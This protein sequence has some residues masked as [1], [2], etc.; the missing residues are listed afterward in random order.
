MVY[1]AFIRRIQAR[2]QGAGWPANRTA[3]LFDCTQGNCLAE[4]QTQLSTIFLTRVLVS[5][6]K[7]ILFPYVGWTNDRRKK[8]R[9]K[10]RA[11]R[12]AA[13]RRSRKKP[14]DT[15]EDDDDDDDDEER[16]DEADEAPT[17]ELSPTEEEFHLKEYHVMFGP[18]RDYAELVVVLGFAT[19]FVAAFPLAPLMALVN[20]YVKIR[21]D[22]WEIAIRSRRPW[23]SGAEDI[24][25]WDA[26]IALMSYLAVLINGLIITFTGGFLENRSNAMRFAIFIG[27][28]HVLL[29]FKYI[30]DILIDDTPT[31]VQIQIRRQD[32]VQ[33]KLIKKIPDPDIDVFTDVITT[34]K[35]KTDTPEVGGGVPGGGPHLTIYDEDDDQ[36]YLDVPG[37]SQ[38]RTEQKT[39]SL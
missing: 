3:R 9:A 27:Y 30:G 38:Y 35:E 13:K 8:R 16:Q 21:V 24:G 20:S 33:A 4:L 23:P 12:A 31:D 25:T 14:Q 29:F 17:R 1:T 10:A 26:I 22:A 37:Y 5:N 15:T 7:S 2:E 28:T 19:L 39:N 32:F 18:L 11:A 6:L 34:S 36:V